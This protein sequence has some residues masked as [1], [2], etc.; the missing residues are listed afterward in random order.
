MSH[1]TN[2]APVNFEVRSDSTP[3]SGNPAASFSPGD[4]GV[5]DFHI[6][7]DAPTER[8]PEVDFG[9]PTGWRTA[10]CL[11]TL[12]SQVNARWPGRRRESDGM[13]GDT[14]HC[15][16]G[17]P[18]SSDHCPWVRDDGTGV[19]TAYDVT[20]DDRDGMCDADALVE[21]IR[22]SK[23]PRVKYIIWNRRIANSSSIQGHPPWTWRPYRGANPHTKHAHISVKPTK[24][25]VSGYDSTA[26]WTIEVE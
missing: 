7:P 10:K 8:A 17:A 16:G 22:A 5:L 2:D 15:G 6:D 18:T 26:S 4:D 23:D 3:S 19:V 12:K 21:A 25:G 1:S 13:I 20:H 11:D 24:D 14:R 9:P